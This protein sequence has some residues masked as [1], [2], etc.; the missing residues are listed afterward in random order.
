MSIEMAG[1]VYCPLSPRD[2]K[3]RLHT[4]IE[5]TQSHVV[6]VHYM[7]QDKFEN[8]IITVDIDAV[9]NN[10]VII[11]NDDLDRLSSIKV[12]SE[13]M[14]YVIFTSGSTGTPKAVS[15]HA[16][17][18]FHV[19]LIV[20]LSLGSSATTKFFVLYSVVNSCWYS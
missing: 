4:L 16:K 19:C 3:Q 20:Y 7:T 13:S 1:G 18:Y 17:K 12:T 10:N 2:P 8:D 5:Q 9:V 6:L 14:A 11:N 15:F